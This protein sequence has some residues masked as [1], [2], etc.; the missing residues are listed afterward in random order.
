M[1]RL[2][3]PRPAQA[4]AKVKLAL[5]ERAFAQM[6]VLARV[7]IPAPPLRQHGEIAS[8]GRQAEEDVSTALAGGSS[9]AAAAAADN[10]ERSVLALDRV[11]EL[12]QSDFGFQVRRAAFS[13][14]AT[15]ATFSC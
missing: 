4:A 5:D 8:V 10:H 3:P 13:R 7:R 6:D 2:T 14:G 9:N 11:R 12:L 1:S 15:L